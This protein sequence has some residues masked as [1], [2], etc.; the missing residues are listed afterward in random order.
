MRLPDVIARYLTAYNDMDI[1]GMMACL[2]PDVTFRDVSDGQVT[3]ETHDRA[4]FAELAETGRTAFST[5]SQTVTNAITVCDTTVVEIDFAATVAIDL[6]NGWTAG[7]A[8]SFR[9]AAFFVLRDGLIARI[10]DA[11]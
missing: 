8:L 10:V 9:G 4:A 7:Q 2:A 11:R 5:R 3:A 6:P 1:P